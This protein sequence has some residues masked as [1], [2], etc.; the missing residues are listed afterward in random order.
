MYNTD[1]DEIVEDQNL[2][3]YKIGQTICLEIDLTDPTRNRPNVLHYV[4]CGDVGSNE[5]A[6][7]PSPEPESTVTWTHVSEDGTLRADYAVNSGIREF[8]TADAPPEFG[9]VFPL[10]LRTTSLG[11][12]GRVTS[13]MESDSTALF[14]S[15]LNVTRNVSTPLYQVLMQAYGLWTCTFNNSLGS[16]TAST[17][18]TDN[19]T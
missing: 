13:I 15:T 10:L 3:I 17:F 9:D 11:L 1:P 14:F 2:N 18:I 7:I 16:D 6:N 12:F 19:C 4:R 5:T 8:H